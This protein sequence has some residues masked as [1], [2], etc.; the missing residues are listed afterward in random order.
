MR[1]WVG[2]GMVALVAAATGACAS[3]AGLG[4]YGECAGACGAAGDRGDDM[5]VDVPD[6]SSTP[7]SDDGASPGERGVTP[8]EGPDDASS[9]TADATSADGPSQ[10]GRTQSEAQSDARVGTGMDAWVDA[11]SEASAPPM[12]GSTCGP[13]GTT[14]RCGAGQVCCATLAT[15][16]NSCAASCASNA[17][18]GCTSASDCPQSAPICCANAALTNDAQNDPPPKCAV[19]AFSSA[20]ATSCLDVP[21][22]SCVFLGI[23]RLCSRDADCQGDVANQC[24][25]YNGAPESWCSVPAVAMVGGGVHQP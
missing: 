17:T 4:D 23:L 7:S 6:D 20:C 10:D 1:T 12:T 8:G 15:Q 19:A 5:H 21:P 18:L 22:Q 24:W 16:T 9:E 13:R 3:L 25:N 14:T 2:A 11:A